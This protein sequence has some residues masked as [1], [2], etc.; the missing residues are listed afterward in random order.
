MAILNINNID[1]DKII[2]SNKVCFKSFIGYKDDE[3]VNPLYIVLPKMSGCARNFD[4][5]K[6]IS[7]LR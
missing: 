1:T 6:C 2:I 4:G 7:F 3:K 5:T